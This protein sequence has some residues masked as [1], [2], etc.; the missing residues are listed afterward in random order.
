VPNGPARTSRTLSPEN[1][2]LTQHEQNN[3]IPL[4]FYF[5]HD[6]P[7][8]DH[9]SVNG[10]FGGNDFFRVRRWKSVSIRVSMIHFFCGNDMVQDMEA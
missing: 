7:P 10:F 9:A 2:P 6:P 5:R 1:Q 8:S 3:A 4:P